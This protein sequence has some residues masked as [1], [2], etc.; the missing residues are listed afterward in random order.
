[1][2]EYRKKTVFIIVIICFIL[3]LTR[4]YY[5]SLSARNIV[6]MD[7]WRS[8]NF[9]ID[10]VMTGEF[11]WEICWEARF[12]QRNFLQLFL[13]SCD[14]RFMRMNCLWE[15]YAGMIVIFFISILLIR[16]WN[17]IS[18]TYENER[19]NT[20]LFECI[21]ILPIIYIPFCLQQWEIMSLQF[22]FAFMIR[23]FCYYLI[24]AKVDKLLHEDM[25][26]NSY[27]LWGVFTAIVIALVSQLYWPALLL[28]LIAAWGVDFVKNKRI[29]KKKTL[30][31]WGPVSMGVFAYLYNLQ[32][33]GQENNGIVSTLVSKDY[34]LAVLYMFPGS[35]IP[36]SVASIFSLSFIIG[37]AV[38]LIAIIIMTV[39]YFFLFKMEQKSY[40]PMMLC[41]YGLFSVGIISYSRFSI[42][43]PSYML[44][45]R[46]TCETLIIWVGV[47]MALAMMI[48]DNK[49]LFIIPMVV[50]V[51]LVAYADRVEMTVA[52]YRG[53]YKDELL[54]MLPELDKYS[55]DELAGF[56]SPPELVR[57]GTRLLEKYSLN[58]FDDTQIDGAL[59]VN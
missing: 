15:A 43:G 52:P 9:L 47:V 5:V 19:S 37:I 14:I 18:S 16:K 38:I 34:W 13:I 56:Q 51:L 36:D 53:N 30:A 58:V 49:R 11:P 45:S 1:M 6:F 57:D 8:I 41:A 21:I 23:L 33:T 22:S 31:F 35:L 24:M 39:I 40:F 50:I 26:L 46:Y 42:F 54:K 12:G 59:I 27:V 25:P 48:K 17:T 3:L 28:S 55:D 20:A 10:P 4:L 32:M 29:Y 44:A 2:A 7:F